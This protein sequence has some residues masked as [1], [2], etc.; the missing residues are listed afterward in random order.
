MG[1]GE[2]ARY[3][4]VAWQNLADVLA[5][6]EAS[7]HVRGA[8]DG[9]D[10]RSRLVAMTASGRRVWK[11]RAQPKIRAYCDEALDGFSINDMAHTLHYLLKMLANMQCIDEK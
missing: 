3:L 11:A 7:G 10:R 4:M 5:R 9:R 2:L 8:P 1:V 6:M